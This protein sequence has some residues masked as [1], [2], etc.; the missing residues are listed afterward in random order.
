[1]SETTKASRRRVLS[2]HPDET[3]ALQ[4]AGNW[5]REA[6]DVLVTRDVQGTTTERPW[7]VTA[8]SMRRADR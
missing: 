4:A 7:A 5:H 2:I 3:A 8:A 6:A 1:M